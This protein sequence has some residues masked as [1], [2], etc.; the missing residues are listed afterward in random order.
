LRWIELQRQLA[1]S[2]VVQ[3]KPQIERKPEIPAEPREA[4]GPWEQFTIADGDDY[5][6]QFGFF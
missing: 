3:P 2:T 1:T 6:L 4:E 5:E